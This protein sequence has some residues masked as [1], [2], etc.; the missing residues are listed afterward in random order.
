LR[1]SLYATNS[2]FFPVRTIVLVSI[3]WIVPSGFGSPKHG[4]IGNLGSSWFNPAP[5]FVGTEKG[6]VSSGAGKAA[7]GIADGDPF[8]VIRSR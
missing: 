4:A 8:T 5:S 3:L 1:T 7:L 2:W 6:S